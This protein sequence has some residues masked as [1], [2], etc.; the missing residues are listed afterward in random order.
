MTTQELLQRARAAK[1]DIAA[2]DTAAKNRALLAMAKALEEHSGD[3]L[4]A[5]RLDLEA[6]RGTISQVMLDRLALSPD[7][8]SGMAAG[9]REVAEL[10]DPVGAV[11]SWVER[12]N[13]LVIEKTAVPMGVIAIIYESRP[14]VTSDAAALALKA[15]SACVLRGGK[16]AHRSA[17]AITDA[18]REGLAA[19]GLSPDVLQLVE[20]TSRTS[21]NELMAA[22][23]LVDL[24]I[25]RGGAG[26][27]RACVD[28]ATVPVI[29]TGTGICHVYVDAYAD[30]DMALDIV[31]NA[32]CS[33]P[34]VC[35]AAE[36]CLVHREVA[37]EFLPKLKDRLEHNRFGHPVQL[38]LDPEAAKIIDGTPAGPP[39]L[40][41]NFWTTSWPSRWWTAWR[42]LWATS[43]PTPPATPR[44]L[45]P[46]TR[47]RPTPS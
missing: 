26:L 16:E 15:G 42:R 28:N 45:S 1:W 7:R 29:E 9:L 44:P 35:N 2:A 39:T 22:R 31:E 23:G 46:A 10:P 11:L 8:I 12:P 14:N 27:I 38:R 30:L 6:A 3:I 21:A 34:S 41:P 18:L 36:V 43:P 37:R 5:N 47:E 17:A 4:A 25:P 19:A 40:T 32:K 13:G 33:R 24:L 20:D